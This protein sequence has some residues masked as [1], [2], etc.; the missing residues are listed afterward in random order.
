[1]SRIED[2]RQALI[3]RQRKI[4]EQKFLELQNRREEAI[5]LVRDKDSIKKIVLIFTKAAY[6]VKGSALR[7]NGIVRKQ[8]TFVP[9]HQDT[10]GFEGSFCTYKVA[11]HYTGTVCLAIPS[12][13]L[14]A[15]TFASKGRVSVRGY[16]FDSEVCKIGHH[17]SNPH[18]R[19][20][21]ARLEF[22]TDFNGVIDSSRLSDF[23]CNAISEVILNRV[24][25]SR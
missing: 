3:D 5:R 13:N 14:C 19:G 9:E 20:T 25:R 2:L 23:A 4:S 11:A 12:F 6:Q 15:E 22:K 16:E 21:P 10:G 8:I 17:I 7:G 18:N 1:M 24:R